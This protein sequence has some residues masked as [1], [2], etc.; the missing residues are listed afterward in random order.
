MKPAIEFQDVSKQYLIG[1]GSLSLRSALAELPLR[2][3]G[4]RSPGKAKLWALRDV[5]FEVRRGESLGVLGHNGAGKTTVLKLLSEITYPTRGS[6]QVRGRLGS[7]IEL[8]AGFHPEMSGRENVYLNGV[9]LGMKRKEVSRKFDSIVDFAGIEK[10]I[11]TP[12]KRYSSGMY[13]RLAFAVAAHIDPAVLLVDEVLAVGDISFRAKCYRRMA[14]LRKNGTTVVLVSHDVYA[15]RDTCDRALL[16][17]Q[18]ELAEE[19]P[20]EGVIT[21]YLARMQQFGT[22][23]SAGARITTPNTG[24]HQA[25]PAKAR[26]ARIENVTILDQHG[27][28]VDTISSGDRLQVE[29]RYHAFEPVSAPIFRIDFYRDGSIYTGYSTAYDKVQMASLEGSGRVVL[30]INAMHTLPGIYTMSAVIAETYEHN[31]LDVHH[32]AYPLQVLRAP[33]SRGGLILPHTWR[34]EN[35]HDS[36]GG[37]ACHE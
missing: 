27:S 8:G 12:V 24:T 9:I 35:S 29:V 1:S 25:V 37:D 15:V 23:P 36:P 16:L 34:L 22:E 30:T 14:E 33:D 10:F 19:G 5:S 11:D 31:L 3:T 20:T 18:G 28:A 32:Q 26:Q 4:R 13:V 2:L 6:I 17:W 21:S 7:L